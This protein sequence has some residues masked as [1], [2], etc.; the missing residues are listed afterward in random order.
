MRSLPRRFGFESLSRLRRAALAVAL[1]ATMAAASFAAPAPN[2]GGPER[3]KKKELQPVVQLLKQARKHVKE[4][5]GDAAE[6]CYRQALTIDDHSS[7]ARTGL[8]LLYVKQRR[9]GDAY[10][11]AERAAKDEPACDQ[12]HALAG[13]IFVRTGNFELAYQRL[14]EALKLNKR[15]DLALAAGAEAACYENQM[16]VADNLLSA[17]LTLNP[18]EPDYYVLLA[19]VASRLENFTVAADALRTFLHLAPK[20]DAERRERIEGV[21]R[22]YSYLGTS[23]VNV[24]N[25]PQ[26]VTIPLAIRGRR[27]HVQVKINN[28][29]PFDFVLDT[30][31]SVSVLSLA[32]AKQIG[33]KPVAS[34]GMARAVGGGGTF[35]IIYGVA[36][37]LEIG[38]VKFSTVPVYLRDIQSARTN[39]TEEAAD[40]FIGLSLLSDFLIMLDY[41]GRSLE[42][43]YAPR[44]GHISST[45]VAAPPVA[46]DGACVVPFR[47]TESGLIS[48]E[49]QL[50]GGH[51]LNFIFDSGAS[52]TVVAHQAI[53]RHGWQDKIVSGQ[54][55]RIV[56]AAGVMENV[57]L[58]KLKS[59]RVSDL[60]KDD[61]RL[62]VLD[63]SRLNESSGFEQMGILGGDFLHHCRVQIDFRAQRLNITPVG[64]GVR[65]A[66][67]E[68]PAVGDAQRR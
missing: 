5:N 48:V 46:K 25:R 2:S 67:P 31:A 33:I 37:S 62:P 61:A 57:S 47:L 19:R 59:V 44:A 66:A 13:L 36:K 18:D 24:V 50:D 21:I 65:R 29:G 14:S 30:G 54:G 26:N 34:G 51:W 28:K 9:Y 42:L 38:D 39:A 60:V 20:T 35:P 45:A 16:D 63:L 3:D 27:P 4:G 53:E 32:V 10:Q 49:T 68:L 12:A 41:Q 6:T 64:G 43:S 58:V 8:A 17:A 11:E 15:N 7:A 56:G 52:T 22:F 23:H 1:G 40:G 55:V